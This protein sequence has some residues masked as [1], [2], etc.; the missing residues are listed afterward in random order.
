MVLSIAENL[1]VSDPR[2]IK[3]SNLLSETEDRIKKNEV[4]PEPPSRGRGRCARECPHGRN[5]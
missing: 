2:I 1:G 5:G 4:R 3:I